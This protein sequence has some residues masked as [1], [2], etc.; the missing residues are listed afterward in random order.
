[1]R[2]FVAESR[3]SAR[4]AAA[5]E[6]SGPVGEGVAPEVV[7][8]PDQRVRVADTR[9]APFRSIGRTELGC[10]G[11]VVGPRHVLT[12]AHC[13]YDRA[14]RRYVPFLD[15]TPAQSGG[16]RPF[17][18]FSWVRALA[19][20]GYTRDGLFRFDYALIVLS[21]PVPAGVGVLR[22]EARPLPAGLPITIAGYPADKPRGTMWRSSCG[23]DGVRTQGLLVYDCDT[24]GGNSGSPVL[25]GGGAALVAVHG[26]GFTDDD[27]G[28]PLEN[29]AAPITASVR[30]QIQAWIAA[31]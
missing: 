12:A 11:A 13:V 25:P 22:I 3:R 17:G 29:G 15:F 19:P 27:T 20:Q 2:L 18:T 16:L 5:A 14:S 7:I 1:V 21:R 26:Y 4:G 8:P 24:A 30:R 23:A 28:R 10:T 31:N 6:G 9:R